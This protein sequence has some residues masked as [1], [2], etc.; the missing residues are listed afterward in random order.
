MSKPFELGLVLAGAI[1][2]GAYSAGVVDF[3]IEALDEFEIA[4]ST[5]RTS[6]GESWDGPMHEV[7]VPVL[8]GA[9]AG[10]MTA[11]IAAL[12][13]FQPFQ[14]YKTGAK[15]SPELNRLYASWV[16]EIDISSL[17]DL[18]DVNKGGPL[19]SVLCSK[20]LE[21]IV[22]RTIQQRPAKKRGWVGRDGALALISTVT[23]LGGV[24]YAFPMTGAAAG[25][26]YGMLNHG[27]DIR[28]LVQRGKA[29]RRDGFRPVDLDPPDNEALGL[30]AAAALATGAFPLGLAA[31]PLTRRF[32]DLKHGQRVGFERIID[33]QLEFVNVPPLEPTPAGDSDF[34]AVDGGVIDNEPFELARRY[35]SNRN[36]Q[37]PENRDGIKTRYSVLL[38]DPFPNRVAW[39]ASA[40]NDRLSA[41]LF[42]LLSALIDQARFKPQELT[43][44]IDR[45]VFSR[46]VISPEPVADSE[47]ARALPI[48]CGALG[49]FSG[50]LD[51][52]YRHHDY[53][54]GRRNAQAFLRWHLCLPKSNPLFDAWRTAAPGQDKKWFVRDVSEWPRG[55]KLGPD[56]DLEFRLKRL[57]KYA[58][59]PDGESEEVLPIIPLARHLREPIEITADDRPRPDEVDLDQL[60]SRLSKRFDRV[61]A[62]LIDDDF[63]DYVPGWVFGRTALKLALPGAA[64]KRTMEAVQGAQEAIRKAFG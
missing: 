38:I 9:S 47:A 6:D 52:S 7:V 42:P 63:R 19:R 55:Q 30:L 29:V 14:P 37:N 57:P 60:R 62:K 11:A 51:K 22:R 58:G 2:A 56:G 3:L 32:A 31:R 13:M 16:D 43:L 27:D 50:F 59:T 15:P 53:L 4:R 48:A 23:N 49:G 21:E 44:A 5:G 54:L 12:Q 26:A 41:V 28:F 20:V 1:S 40:N 8:S 45:S 33:G 34:V 10:G 39:P 35:L 64:T 36:T 25:A 24:P 17:L 18:E 61:I 46:H